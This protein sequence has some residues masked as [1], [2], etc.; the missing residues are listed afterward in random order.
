MSR[1]GSKAAVDVSPSEDLYLIG[2][3]SVGSSSTR[4]GTNPS[5]PSK[6]EQHHLLQVAEDGEFSPF[7]DKNNSNHNNNNN[8]NNNNNEHTN[9]NINND[10]TTTQ[11]FS[12]S[13]P[14]KGRSASFSQKDIQPQPH[15]LPPNRRKS[16]SMIPTTDS[17]TPSSRQNM[18]TTRRKSSAVVSTPK[19][20][21]DPLSISSSTAPTHSNRH[22]RAA[23]AAGDHH[24]DQP[25][26][27]R[28]KSITW[29]EDT[30]SPGKTRK[31][32]VP[33]PSHNAD[34][35]TDSDARATMTSTVGKSEPFADPFQA[36]SAPTQ[37]AKH[38][39]VTVR[40]LSRPSTKRSSVTRAK[41][42]D[43][44]SPS[45]SRRGSEAGGGPKKLRRGSVRGGS[46]KGGLNVHLARGVDGLN[47]VS[48]L[49]V[50]ALLAAAYSEEEEE[51][52]LWV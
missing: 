32:S 1:R 49:A 13:S 41:G 36:P 9:S 16:L 11:T 38:A 51:V 40:K 2:T 30:S 5:S 47:G 44:G 17:T 6:E 8:N 15:Q 45:G 7:L 39:A 27:N 23:A 31:P 14:S 37:H 42:A 21:H 50:G 18:T 3:S 33:T 26:Q 35:D 12:S 29:S 4:R 52:N 25:A 43:E 24:T 34:A 20:L 22:S 48:S 19:D 46:E 10:T 28:R